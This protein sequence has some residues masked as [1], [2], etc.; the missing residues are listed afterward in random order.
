V[1]SANSRGVLLKALG[2]TPPEGAGG[3]EVSASVSEKVS[4]ITDL[5]HDPLVRMGVE[6]LTLYMNVWYEFERL[7][8]WSG[9]LWPMTLADH[10]PKLLIPILTV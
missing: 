2:P 8:R 10:P 4:G 6:R 5:E 1:L 9:R 7:E 3:T